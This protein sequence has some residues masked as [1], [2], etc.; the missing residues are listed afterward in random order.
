MIKIGINNAHNEERVTFCIWDTGIGISPDDIKKLFTRFTQIE[1][2][3]KK[4]YEGTGLGLL[5]EKMGRTSGRANP[6]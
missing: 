2:P 5:F 3:Y 6:G 4:K 1:N